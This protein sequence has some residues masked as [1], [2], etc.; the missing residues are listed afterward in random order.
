MA[1]NLRFVADSLQVD[2]HLVDIKPVIAR[3]RRVLERFL[4]ERGEMFAESI[5][6]GQMMLFSGAELEECATHD[7]A[8]RPDA[9][10]IRE[11]IIPLLS[12]TI[13]RTLISHSD[14]AQLTCA[15]SLTVTRC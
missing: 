14:L 9:T 15:Q 7:L 4:Y 2:L 10:S 3:T 1:G 5:I 12:L 11:N 13:E 6:R 8:G